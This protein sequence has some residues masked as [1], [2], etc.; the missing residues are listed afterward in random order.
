MPARP[1]QSQL[2]AQPTVPQQDARTNLLT[3]AS[4]SQANIQQ[5]TTPEN[6]EWKE[7]N[8]RGFKGNDKRKLS[9][10]SPGR[11]SKRASQEDDTH[12]DHVDSNQEKREEEAEICQNDQLDAE[13]IPQMDGIMN[14]LI[15]SEEKKLDSIRGDKKAKS[16]NDKMKEKEGSEER[17]NSLAEKETTDWSVEMDKEEEVLDVGQKDGKATDRSMET[18]KGKR[19]VTSYGT[20][21]SISGRN[22]KFKCL[23]SGSIFVTDKS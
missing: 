11:A 22:Q 2:P 10:S 15:D 20:L 8:K 23:E 6:V 12:T 4:G 14:Q 18:E 21:V 1:T 7:T 5:Q 9:G 13:K 19:E 16:R 3:Q 17:P